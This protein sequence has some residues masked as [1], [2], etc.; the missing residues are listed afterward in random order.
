MA[1][2]A[3]DYLE[4]WGGDVEKG[5]AYMPTLKEDMEQAEKN[6]Q[7]AEEKQRELLEKTA[8]R[9]RLE[10]DEVEDFL[11]ENYADR[12][13]CEYLVDGAILTCTNC[14]RDDV[15]VE[16]V[17][18]SKDPVPVI[19]IYR[20][21]L[22]PSIDD[23]M[24]PDNDTKVFGRLKVTENLT[25]NTNGLKHA[26]IKDR[27][28]GKNIPS[29]GNCL[30]APD[31]ILEESP[32]IMLDF[33]RQV[34]MKLDLKS[35]GAGNKGKT[36]DGEE[37]NNMRGGT[38]R[39][40]MR[41]ENEWENYE[42]GQSFQ[43]FN[44]DVE[45][46]KAGITMTSILFCKHGG[47][48]YPVTSGQMEQMHITIDGW[49]KLYLNP[50]VNVEGR[51]VPKH[52]DANN[53]DWAMPENLSGKDSFENGSAAHGEIT[54]YGKFDVEMSSNNLYIDSA[55]R[56]WVAVGPNVMNK[57]RPKVHGPIY[58]AEMNY[59]TKLDIVVEDKEGRRYYIPAVVGDVKGH[60]FPDGKY[61]TGIPFDEKEEECPETAGNTVEFLGYDITKKVYEDG[62]EKSSINVTNNYKLIE[63]LV[64]D[65]EVNY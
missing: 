34:K 57:D 29:F 47:F 59:G 60:S 6:R 38:C 20:A 37:S 17:V 8:E 19:S 40:L 64:Y 23:S 44:D 53:F 65:G 39:Y 31:C 21:E 16:T 45:G 48:I 46:N 3:V 13:S 42:I 24:L 43:S 51:P 1:K 36:D 30:R 15:S 58:A 25:A 12:E 49:L 61:Q 56:Y 62:K 33:M 11:C 55:G 26:T 35:S 7:V 14:T 32:F 18:T 10:D 9:Y 4:H 54:K 5:N 27:E 41:L 2:E 22:D 50:T 63:I 28:R 52:P